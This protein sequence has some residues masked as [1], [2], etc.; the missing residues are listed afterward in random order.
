MHPCSVF[1]SP[2]QLLHFKLLLFLVKSRLGTGCVQPC[3]QEP[4]LA[5][6]NALGKAH[7]EEEE[8][9]WWWDAGERG[10]GSYRKEGKKSPGIS[11]HQLPSLP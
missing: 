11:C 1:P 3:P 6:E 2:Q 9:T 5:V 7:T 8:E 10:R 4:S